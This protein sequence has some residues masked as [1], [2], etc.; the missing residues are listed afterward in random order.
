MKKMINCYA[1]KF[2]LNISS[3]DSNDLTMPKFLLYNILILKHN[4]GIEPANLSMVSI[5]SNNYATFH[6]TFLIPLLCYSTQIA[7]LI[8]HFNTN[9]HEQKRNV[10]KPYVMQ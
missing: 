6:V 2:K 1:L 10:P 5:H 7:A 4:T 3:N 8:F 9:K